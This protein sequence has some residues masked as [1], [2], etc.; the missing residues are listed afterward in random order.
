ML[1]LQALCIFSLQGRLP[2]P[3]SP[4]CSRHPA[5]FA[6]CPFQFLVYFSVF[7]PPGW[8][9]DCPGGMLVY[10]RDGCGIQCAAY[11]LTC[12]S[13]SPKQVRSQ[14]LAV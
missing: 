1:L 14:L 7:F 4:V 3:T 12:W 9:S 2:L 5:L 13:A 10:P 6:M 11:L 8:G